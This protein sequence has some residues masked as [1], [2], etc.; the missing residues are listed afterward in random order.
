MISY[1]LVVVILG[2]SIGLDAFTKKAE[3]SGG[4]VTLYLKDETAEHWLGTD[5][6]TNGQCGWNVL[7]YSIVYTQGILILGKAEKGFT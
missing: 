7:L 2:T 5:I 6:K 4:Y 3:A 1:L